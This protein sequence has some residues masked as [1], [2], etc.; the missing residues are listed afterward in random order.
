M[1][2]MK[3]CINYT[4]NTIQAISPLIHTIHCVYRMCG[5]PNKL[6][7]HTVHDCE[8]DLY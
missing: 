5:Q 8:T 3:T 7:V 2:V 4:Y 6:L 1:L